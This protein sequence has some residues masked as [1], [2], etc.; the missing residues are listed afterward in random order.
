MK[1]I[2]IETK[3]SSAI[4]A[5]LN[6]VNGKAHGHTYTTFSYIGCI[7]N[8]AEIKA[9]RL[10]GSRKGAIGATV[11]STSGDKMPNAYAK[12]AFTRAATRVTLERRP[13]GWF[14]TSVERADVYQQGGGDD[15]LTLTQVQADIAL[16]RFKQAFRVAG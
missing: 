16:A 11:I 4:T 10:I 14:L 2:K 12:K 9:I 13:T 5:A 3:N 7:A 15:V 6:A 8:A 1:A